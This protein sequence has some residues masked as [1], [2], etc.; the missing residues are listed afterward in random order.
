[1]SVNKN[2][3]VPDGNEFIIPTRF[4]LIIGLTASGLSIRRTAGK[5]WADPC[6]LK[7]PYDTQSFDCVTPREDGC[8]RE[9]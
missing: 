6:P 1:M 4:W 3:T 7:Y 5:D 8:R 9:S 2:V